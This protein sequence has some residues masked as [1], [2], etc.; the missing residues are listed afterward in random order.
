MFC[1]DAAVSK[2]KVGR[3]LAEIFQRLASTAS[4]PFPIAFGH[5][6]VSWLPC[7]RNNLH[8]LFRRRQ[9]RHPDVLLDVGLP[10]ISPVDVDMRGR[11]WVDIGITLSP[12]QFP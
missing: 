9:L 2:S 10:G 1:I 4:G 3:P 8:F 5:I 7:W 6:S 11:G 12:V